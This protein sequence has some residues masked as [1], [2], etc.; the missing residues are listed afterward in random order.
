MAAIQTFKNLQ[1]K[2]LAWLDEAGDTGTTLTLVKQALNESN[3]KRATQ[4][5]WLWMKWD[6][7]ELLA[8]VANRQVYTLHAEFF[9]P[10]YF[11]NRTELDYVTQYDDSTIVGSGVDE[12]TDAGPALK[13]KFVGR[14]EVAAQPSAAS[15]LLASSS[16]AAADAAATVT[17]RGDTTLGVRSETLTQG[18]AGS[19]SFTRILKVTKNGTWAGTLTLTSNAAA[20]TNLVLFA[21]EYGRSY[22][23]V[24]FLAVPDAPAVVE[25]TFYRQPVTMVADNDRPDIPTPFEELLVWDT[26][27]SFAGYN[28][29]DGQ[30]VKIWM[31]KQAEQLLA[32]QQAED[33]RALEAATNYTVY[34]PR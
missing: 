17:V 27:L 29:Y 11:W 3:K 9:R 7:P 22:P 16:N 6:S 28:T 25:Y 20:V 15:V 13:F 26:L 8:I 1:D 34:I 30:M 12:N 5:R 32:L 21:E 10:D 23:Q 19:V 18:V 2:V 31:T 33:A 24:K 14:T 4:E